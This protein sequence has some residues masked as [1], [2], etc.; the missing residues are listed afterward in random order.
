MLPYLKKNDNEQPI[1]KSMS[2]FMQNGHCLEF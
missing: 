1:L 2:N